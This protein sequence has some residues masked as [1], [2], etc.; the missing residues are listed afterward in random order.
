MVTISLAFIYHQIIVTPLGFSLKLKKC[1]M[2]TLATKMLKI[3]T[4]NEYL[5]L[6]TL[7]KESHS[8]WKA[9]E[10]EIGKKTAKENINEFI[11]SIPEKLEPPS[12]INAIIS[13]LS[14]INKH[15]DSALVF[16]QS[17][18]FL[19]LLKH[20]LEKDNISNTVTI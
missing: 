4:P 3:T 8:I 14:K 7:S 13:K 15:G 17:A 18:R 1:K 16:S 11:D 6:L 9:V 10:Y 19:I 5:N 12:K 20:F 2:Y